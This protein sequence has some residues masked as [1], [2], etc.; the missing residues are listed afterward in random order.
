[1]FTNSTVV[2]HSL[3]NY[4]ATAKTMSYR[5][6]STPNVSACHSQQEESQINQI[7]EVLFWTAAAVS[8]LMTILG[9]IANCLVIYFSIQEPWTGTLRYLN[10]VVKHLA[11]SDLLLGVLATPFCLVYWKMGKTYT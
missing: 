7:N 5:L 6:L 1:M 11:V 3:V 4:C 9:T 2:C 10:K 8:T